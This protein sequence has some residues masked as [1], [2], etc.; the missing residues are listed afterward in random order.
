MGQRAYMAVVTGSTIIGLIVCVLVA[1][2]TLAWQPSLGELLL[3]GLAVPIIGILIA[4]RRDEWYLSFIGYLLVVTGLGAI[5]GPGVTHY[6]TSVVLNALFATGGVTIVMS[7]VGISYPNLLRGWGSYLFAA[8]TALIL[9]RIGQSVAL[10]L[11][12]PPSVAGLPFIDYI[13]AALFSVYI[14]YDWGRALLLPYTLDNAIDASVAIFLD[15]VNLFLS[16]LRIF[17]DSWRSDD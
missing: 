16:L 14:V 11:S 2:K 5:I 1:L 9:V 12:V 15:V 13:A 10:G 7:L 3:V 4:L 17:G 8:L 6:K